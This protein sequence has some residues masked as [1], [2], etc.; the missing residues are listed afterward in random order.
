MLAITRILCPV[1]LSDISRRALRQALLLARQLQ[2][3]VVVLYVVDPGVSPGG[4]DAAPLELPPDVRASFEEDLQWFVAPMVDPQLPVEMEVRVGAIV[5]EILA[6]SESMRADLIVIGTH[7]RSGFE[8][9]A[10]GSVA[11][12]V[13]RKAGCPVLAVPGQAEGPPAPVR[14]VLCPT[15]GSASSD[16]AVAY[17][18]FMAR[19]SGAS[20]ILVTVVDWPFGESTA[21]N[22]VMDLRRSIEAEAQARLDAAVLPDG[23]PSRTAVL[24]GKPWRAITDFARTEHVGLIV[25]GLS[26]RGAVD[27]ALLGSTTHHVIRDAPCPVLTVGGA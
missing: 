12:K 22:A 13:L 17:A 4:G 25:M 6:G 27:L 18:R 11:E 10:L 21:Q 7:G 24:R 26:G 1:D 19:A 3:R 2:A 5:P 14:Q 20:L 16:R 8:R 15:D 23:P 9:L